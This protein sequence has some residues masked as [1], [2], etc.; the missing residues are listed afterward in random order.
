[1]G[2]DSKKIHLLICIGMQDIAKLLGHGFPGIIL[3]PP[4]CHRHVNTNKV[5]ERGKNVVFQK[6]TWKIK[7]YSE[8]KY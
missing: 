3:L 7:M 6:I 1:M 4:R 5:K 8:R 2:Y